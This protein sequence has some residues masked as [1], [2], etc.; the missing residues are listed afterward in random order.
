MKHLPDGIEHLGG[1][2]SDGHFLSHKPLAAGKFEIVDVLKP[3]Q[4]TKFANRSGRLRNTRSS[5]VI[6]DSNHETVRRRSNPKNAN[7]V[8]ELQAELA[9]L[10]KRYQVPDDR[11]K[12]N[13]SELSSPTILDQPKLSKHAN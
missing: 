2:D 11:G 4:F 10:Q 9:R 13:D 6:T 5:T 12:L 1:S 8:K 7:L 3:K